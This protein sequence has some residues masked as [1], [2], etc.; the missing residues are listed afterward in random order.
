MD[1]N[2][3]RKHLQSLAEESTVLYPTKYPGI[4]I[5]LPPDKSGTIVIKNGK[6]HNLKVG[7]VVTITQNG[8]T[9]KNVKLVSVVDVK[10]EP[11]GGKVRF[12]HLGGE[13]SLSGNGIEF[14]EK[15]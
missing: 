10:H 8:N 9:Y 14:I 11:L 5:T 3:F 4:M 7:D 12:A 2:Q 13:L 15:V 6:K 1:I